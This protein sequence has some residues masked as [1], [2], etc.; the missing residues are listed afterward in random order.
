M[1]KLLETVYIFHHIGGGI[2]TISCEGGTVFQGKYG[3]KSLWGR[4]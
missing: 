2:S 1:V 3:G 4:G